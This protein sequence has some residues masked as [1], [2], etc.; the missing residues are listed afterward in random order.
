MEDNPSPLPLRVGTRGESSTSCTFPFLSLI[1]L[2]VL[3]DFA[4]YCPSCWLWTFL[5]FHVFSISLLSLSL[6]LLFYRPSLSISIQTHR[7]FSTLS[8]NCYSRVFK[9]DFYYN[10][11]LKGLS[12]SNFIV[13]DKIDLKENFTKITMIFNSCLL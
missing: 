3:F 11:N 7:L 4:F 12:D 1:H 9:S 10:I 13:I 6:V 2:T 5:A 8:Y